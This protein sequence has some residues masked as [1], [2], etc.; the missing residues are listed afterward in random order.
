MA[1]VAERRL[2]PCPE[3]GHFKDTL[4]NTLR[5]EIAKSL[6]KTNK[7]IPVLN[8]KTLLYFPQ[9][10]SDLAFEQV[11]KLQL[12]VSGW[13]FRDGFIHFD[14]EHKNDSISDN[15]AIIKNVLC[16]AELIESIV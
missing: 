4:V 11:L 16:Y 5:Y 1:P 15:S 14:I 10:Q 8:C 3:F 13:E 6:E 12:D 2:A 7:K 9:E